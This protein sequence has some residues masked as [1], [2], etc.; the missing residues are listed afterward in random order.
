MKSH[1]WNNYF[2]ISLT[3]I[4]FNYYFLLMTKGEI[5]HLNESIGAVIGAITLLS[6]IQYSLFQLNYNDNLHSV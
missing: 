1:D 4:M 5:S 3:Y 2:I 6:L